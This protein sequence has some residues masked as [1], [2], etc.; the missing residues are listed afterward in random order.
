MHDPRRDSLG[1]LPSHGG[2]SYGEVPPPVGLLPPEVYPSS[3]DVTRH[4]MGHYENLPATEG[5][6]GPAGYDGLADHAP[7]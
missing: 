1:P 4:L 6:Y 7:E 5:L 3:H 2:P